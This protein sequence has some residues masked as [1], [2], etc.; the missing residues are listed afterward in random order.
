LR[1]DTRYGPFDSVPRHAR[2]TLPDVPLHVIQRGNNRQAIFFADEDYRRYL[3]ALHVAAG[4]SVCAIHAYCLMTNHVHLLL[5]P[6]TEDG[7]AVLM[8]QVGQQ[9]AQYI[10]RTYCRSGT[11]WEGR[12][13]PAPV[14]AEEYLLAC[15]RY[16]ERNPVR[17]RMV[18]Q[19]GDY[20]WSSYGWHGG[21]WWMKRS[22]PC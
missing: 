19:P 5:T 22:I 7:C 10:N 11:L 4:R 15:Q 18:A 1:I 21:H 3:D 16:I 20:R 8:K 2:F 13:R 17:A 14:Q 9:H 12:F 6:A